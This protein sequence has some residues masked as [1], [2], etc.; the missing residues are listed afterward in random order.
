MSEQRERPLLDWERKWGGES[1]LGLLWK[2]EWGWEQP[3]EL[4]WDWEW[5]A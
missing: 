2:V 5:E 1:L 4:E 3:L